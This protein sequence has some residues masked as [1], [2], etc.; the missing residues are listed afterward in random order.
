MTYI[1]RYIA[2]VHPVFHAN[3]YAFIQTNCSVL[4][5]IGWILGCLI[6][7]ISL[8]HCETRKFKY[9]DEDY[10][11]CGLVYDNENTQKAYVLLLFIF[12]FLLPLLLQTTFY[13]SIALKIR[14]LKNSL[15]VNKIKITKML[16]ILLLMFAICWLPIRLFFV[17]IV[18]NKQ[19]LEFQTST[20]YHVYVFT[21]FI[22]HFL[23]MFNSCI[24]PI[25][26]CFMSKSFR[27]C[28]YVC[29]V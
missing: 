25:V 23:S 22:A 29:R 19:L 6:S 26:Y 7:C 13:L 14:S 15:S 4:L 18:F 24:N 27:V 2:I 21:Y 1:P 11:D 10:Y 16:A 5:V 20:Q 3:R 17:V 8:T 9:K 12:T 28:M